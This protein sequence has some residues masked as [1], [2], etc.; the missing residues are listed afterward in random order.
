MNQYACAAF[1]TFETTRVCSENVYARNSDELSQFVNATFYR[2]M[3][4]ICTGRYG[5]LF[6]LST[7]DRSSSR[8]FPRLGQ[9]RMNATW[10]SSN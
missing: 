8:G 1:R 5:R 6:A 10:L 2:L 9:L 7:P 4:L 3:L